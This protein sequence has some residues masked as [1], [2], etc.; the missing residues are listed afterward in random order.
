MRRLQ[1]RVYKVFVQSRD[2]I[3]AEA[4]G[5]GFAVYLESQL[6]IIVGNFGLKYPIIMGN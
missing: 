3:W 1:F 6:P 2:R 4:Y 5:L